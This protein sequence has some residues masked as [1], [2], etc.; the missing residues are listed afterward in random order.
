MTTELL[1]ARNFSKSFYG[2]T[3]L[4]EVDVTVMAGEVHALLG[5]NGSGKSTFIKCLS[6]YHGPESG[7]ELVVAGSSVD[8]PLDAKTP[9]VLGLAFVHQQLGLAPTLT[10]LE[11]LQVGRFRTGAGWRIRWGENEREV[12]RAL[13]R[14]GGES[15]EP[16]ALVGSL[17]EVQRA[18]VAVARAF[19]EIEAAGGTGVLVLDEPTAYLPRDGVEHLFE[20]IARVTAAGSGVLFVTH[21]LDEVRQ[22]AD[23]VTVL[24]DGVRVATAEATALS[25]R[26]LIELIVGRSLTELYPVA[27]QVRDDVVLEADGLSGSRVSGVSLRLHRGET[28]GVTGL[29]GMGQ[30]AI[31]YLLFG[32]EPAT[33]GQLTVDGATA[34]LAHLRPRKAM[35]LGLSLVPAD[36]LRNGGVGSA[37]VRENVTV[38]VLDKFLRGGRINRTRER[39]AVLDRIGE[40][41]V[42]PPDPEHS[43]AE[44]SGGNQQKVVLAKWFATEPSVLLLHEPTQGVDVGARQEVFRHIR[45]FTD[46]GG[47]VII[48]STEYEDLA[49]LCD[50][51]IVFRDG[52]PVAELQGEQLTPEA[53]VEQAFLVTQTER[54]SA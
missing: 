48:A 30:E 38:T 29:L 35:K 9:R 45:R 24:R 25:E 46:R 31:P 40:L 1:T 54:K 18:L 41:Q 27:G 7:A 47:A 33:G 5:Q 19:Q 43:F 39:R 11:N 2:R 15:I 26:D 42:R 10:V 16:Q 4:R 20:A 6:G 37:S 13:A 12:R 51:V 44:L 28:V 23:R 49:H 50:R 52:R 8:L 32:A 53:I 14:V 22:L 34:D 21:R 3:V 36:R 17:T